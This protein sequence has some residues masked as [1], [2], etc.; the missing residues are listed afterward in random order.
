M[1]TGVVV[2]APATVANVGPGFDAVAFALEW[3]NEI[4][5][6]PAPSLRV[7]AEGEGASHL[8]LDDTNLV[9]RAMARGLGAPP[10]AHVHLVN[11]I[12]FGRGLGS[13]AAAIVGGLLAAGA[14][15]G[16]T[17]GASMLEAAVD[18]EGHADNVTACMLGGFTV[19][20]P[21]TSPARLEPPADWEALLVVAPYPLDTHAARRALPATVPFDVAARTAGRAARLVAAIALGD[22][23][24][25]LSAT[26]DELH[27]PARFTLAPDAGKLVARLR[28]DGVAAFLSG[29]GPSV[30]A[31]VP[32]DRIDD[33]ERLARGVAP[34]GWTVHKRPF[35]AN[36]AEV[37]ERG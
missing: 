32:R 25:V 16:E 3:R 35:G 7:T 2:R 11:R 23:P 24:A 28:A 21:G 26:E 31:L 14:S 4:H 22:F 27:Q 1:I 30:A 20:P 8:P 10:R 29:A 15:R 34:D 9:V 12:P 6:D 5:V 13:S 33:A 36:G 37:V 19:S 17:A 18:M